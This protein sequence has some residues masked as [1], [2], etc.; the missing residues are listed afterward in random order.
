MKTV[1][2]RGLS[3]YN[4]LIVTPT[5]QQTH[6]YMP[7]PYRKHFLKQPPHEKNLLRKICF[8]LGDEIPGNAFEMLL[9]EFPFAVHIK[10]EAKPQYKT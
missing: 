5:A 6:Q 2:C 9:K 1:K 3:V 4:E 8:F 10:Q 7:S